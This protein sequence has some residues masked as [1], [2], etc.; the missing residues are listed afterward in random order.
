MKE[1]NLWSNWIRNN[2]EKPTYA[3]RNLA[4]TNKKLVL[5]C[6]TDE[7]ARCGLGHHTAM[8]PYWYVVAA[9]SALVLDPLS[10]LVVK[11][12]VLQNALCKSACTGWK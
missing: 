2:E 3:V 8:D 7:D 1:P 5:A 10:R 9:F 11:D 12:G 4:G 6:C